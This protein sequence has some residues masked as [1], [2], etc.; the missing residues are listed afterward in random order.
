MERGLNGGGQADFS[1][2]VKSAYRH[3][4]VCCKRY[5]ISATHFSLHGSTDEDVYSEEQ[6]SAMG[7]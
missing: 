6:F 1:I 2:K 5:N 3:D 7:A 4:A